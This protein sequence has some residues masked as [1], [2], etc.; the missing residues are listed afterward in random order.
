MHRAYLNPLPTDG[1]LDSKTA[2]RFTR[3]LRLKTGD[4]IEL[5]DGEGH[6]MRAQLELLDTP[7]L[8]NTETFD[9]EPEQPQITLYQ[10]LVSMEKLEFITQRCTELGLSKLVLFKAEHSQVDFKNKLEAKLERLKR[11]AQDASRQSG[12]AWVPKIVFSPSPLEGEGWGEG[13]FIGNPKAS[14][15]FRVKPGMTQI[16]VLIGPEGDFSPQEFESF[17]SQGAKAVRLAP[18]IL[19]TE[20]ASLTA[21]AQIQGAL[22]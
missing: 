12:R 14:T 19:R 16:G 5:F 6:I 10:A 4:K 17:K 13:L 11:I 8:L 7:K 3:I 1:L 15:G 18:N 9:V 2:H 21:L 22:L 20:T